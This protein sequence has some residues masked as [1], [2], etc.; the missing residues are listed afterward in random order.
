MTSRKLL[1]AAAD[2]NKDPILKILLKYCPPTVETVKCLEIASGSGQHVVH[3]G[4]HM[5]HVEFQPSD[6][7]PDNLNSIQDYVSEA[8]LI[9]VQP[10]LSI[11]IL[12]DISQWNLP[13]Q[14]YDLMVNINMIHISP[15]Q[16]SVSLFEKAS[17][18]LKPKALLVTYGPYAIHGLISPESNVNFHQ[19]LLQRNPLWGLRDIDDLQRVAAEHHLTLQ[20]VE[21]MPSNNKMLL[22]CK[23]WIPSVQVGE[24]YLGC[25]FVSLC[26]GWKYV[27]LLTLYYKEKKQALMDLFVP[28]LT[29][30]RNE[31]KCL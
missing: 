5:P 6:C 19:S 2:R 4:L 25:K 13:H 30:I 15:W 26:L 28:T 16:C 22:W 23:Q 14:Q 18:L 20:A 12:S 1:A 17:K 24:Y 8:D 29:I 10:P 31:W 11:D 9:N 7:D 27:P 21:D 3:F